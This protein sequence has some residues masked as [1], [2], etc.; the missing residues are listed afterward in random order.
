MRTLI[1]RYLL[2]VLVPLPVVAAPPAAAHEGVCTGVFRMTLSEGLG[3]QLLTTN[4]SDFTI[5]LEYGA[6]SDLESDLIIDGTLVGACDL[7]SGTGTANGDHELSFV[8]DT[9]LIV[10]GEVT[11]ILYAAL[12]AT[13]PG[14]CIQETAA[15]FLMTGTLVM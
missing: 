5:E 15:H 11:G 4:T 8:W 14:N 10:G 7:A 12:D 1:R 2:L 3:I 6:C 13:Q 9:V